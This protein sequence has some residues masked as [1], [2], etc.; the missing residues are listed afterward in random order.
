MFVITPASFVFDSSV[1]FGIVHALRTSIVL[2]TCPS[3]SAS[4]TISLTLIATVVSLARVILPADSLWAACA[5]VRFLQSA[6]KEGLWHSLSSSMVHGAASVRVQRS[7]FGFFSEAS[8]TVPC[9]KIPLPQCFDPDRSEGLLIAKA[10]FMPHRAAAQCLMADAV[11][12]TSVSVSSA[13]PRW[14]QWM[15]HPPMSISTSGAA[16]C[17]TLITT[18]TCSI[19]SAPRVR[20][21]SSVGS[22][23][24]RGR[25]TCSGAPHPRASQNTNVLSGSPRVIWDRVSLPLRMPM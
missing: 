16:C 23:S 24:S 19:V 6:S 10:S 3:S 1:E 22:V 4:V 7:S 15:S 20:F 12:L 18:F 11:R 25:P 13:L 8:S 21:C 14:S 2:S 17:F 9:R 5:R